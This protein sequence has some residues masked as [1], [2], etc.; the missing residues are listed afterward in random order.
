MSFKLIIGIPSYNEKD[1]ISNVVKDIDNALCLLPYPITA[2]IV[3]SDNNSTD[4]TREAFLNTSTQNKKISLVTT[5]KGKGWNFKNIFD[6]FSENNFDAIIFMDSDLVYVSEE[7]ITKLTKKLLDG[8][9]AVYTRRLPRWNNG[10]LTY[11]VALPVLKSFFGANIHEPISGDFG[12]SKRLVNMAQSYHWDTNIMGYGIDFFLSSLT[13]ELKWC[14]IILNCKKDHKLRSYSRNSNG[15]ITMNPKFKE[16][17]FTVKHMIS[18]KYSFPEFNIKT[19]VADNFYGENTFNLEPAPQFDSDIEELKLSVQKMYLLNEIAFKKQ[20]INCESYFNR[21][22]FIGIPSTYWFQCL[23]QFIQTED[24]LVNSKSI[25]LMENIF[26]CRV[27]GFHNE[28]QG[29]KDWYDIVEKYTF[30]FP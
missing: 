5:Q 4:L 13:T 22:K 12:F 27:I 26:F 19:N 3:N 20:F 30:S 15:F 16:V 1:T 8:Y 17:L 10:D 6:Y 29:I 21:K 11:H 9:D 2:Y 28:I 25:D 24:S 23:K 7:W 18:L 14:E